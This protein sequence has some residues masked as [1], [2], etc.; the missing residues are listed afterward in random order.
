MSLIKYRVIDISLITVV[1]VVTEI[2][3]CYLMNLFMPAVIPVFVASLVIIYIAIMRWGFWGLI[4]I[5]IMTL[6][7]F[8]AI[9]FVIPYT[10][11]N[12]NFEQVDQNFVSILVFNLVAGGFWLLF[13]K[14]DEKEGK[15]L[16]SIPKRIGITVLIYIICSIFC[17]LTLIFSDYHFI[18]TFVRMLVQQALSLVITL[19][20]IEILVNFNCAQDVKEMMIKKKREMEFEKEFYKNQKE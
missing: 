14:L 15:V 10:T 3:G 1:G 5:P 8:I 11:I 6:A 2:L 19:V 12:S 16:D 17:S 18:I 9:S 4:E 20:V 13:K 7:T